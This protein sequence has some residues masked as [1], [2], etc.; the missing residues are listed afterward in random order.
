MWKRW[1]GLV[2]TYPGVVSQE[3]GS[4]QCRPLSLEQKGLLTPAQPYRFQAGMCFPPLASNEQFG[5]PHTTLK[6][7]F[8]LKGVVRIAP[9]G[10]SQRKVQLDNRHFLLKRSLRVG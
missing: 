7:P 2:C 6:Q 9:P 5:K 4:H 3:L 1:Y 8:E 10:P